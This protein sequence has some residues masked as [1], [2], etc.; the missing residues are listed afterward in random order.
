MRNK[1]VVAIM[2]ATVIALAGCITK[3]KLVR[4]DRRWNGEL[5]T[6]SRSRGGSGDGGAS[7]TLAA[8]MRF[9][10][11]A[12]GLVSGSAKD[13][14]HKIFWSLSGQ[15]TSHQLGIDFKKPSQQGRGGLLKEMH[16]EALIRL[17]PDGRSFY[18]G[19][20]WSG[21]LVKVKLTRP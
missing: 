4:I 19:G 6:V 3:D 21:H 13:S 15:M 11:T 2:A 16:L 7:E 9:W 17:S 10:T 1:V 8:T 5:H 18:G 14:S 12:E 20:D